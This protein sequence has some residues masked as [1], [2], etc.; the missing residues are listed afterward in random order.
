MTTAEAAQEVQTVAEGLYQR[1]PD[2]VTF[3]REILG[4]NG[5]VRRLYRTPE[6][7]AEFEQSETYDQIQRMINDLRKGKAAPVDEKEEPTRV[8]T[9]RMP[10]SLHESL[11]EEAHDLRTSMNKLC[12]SKLIQIIDEQ[13]VPGRPAPERAK[14]M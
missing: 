2:W 8:I 4:V 12:I 6:A 7:F 9:V 5:V 11:Q 10:K 14:V 13:R 1:R 3:Y